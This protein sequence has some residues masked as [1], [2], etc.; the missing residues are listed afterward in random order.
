MSQAQAQS[1]SSPSPTDRHAIQEGFLSAANARLQDNVLVALYPAAVRLEGLL[2]GKGAPSN[3]PFVYVCEIASSVLSAPYLASL[4]ISAEDWRR[5]FRHLLDSNFAI[6]IRYIE[7]GK[8]DLQHTDVVV[9]TGSQARGIVVGMAKADK[10]IDHEARPF[11]K[12][13]ILGNVESASASVAKMEEEARGV[14]RRRADAEAAARESAQRAERERAAAELAARERAESAKRLQARIEAAETA[15]LAEM[16]EVGA[17]LYN[18]KGDFP[19]DA[20]RGRHL[21]EKA[22]DAGHVPAMLMLAGLAA[23]P[24]GF[25]EDNR[26]AFEWYEKASAT[27]SVEAKERLAELRKRVSG[28]D[29]R[30]LYEV[31]LPYAQWGGTGLLLLALMFGL[32]HWRQ[33]LFELVGAALGLAYKVD[34]ATSNPATADGLAGLVLAGA[35]GVLVLS[36]GG[37]WL[38]KSTSSVSTPLE[39]PSRNREFDISTCLHDCTETTSVCM[40]RLPRPTDAS[41]VIQRANGVEQ[42]RRYYDVCTASCGKIDECLRLRAAGA[43]DSYLKEKCR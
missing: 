10:L 16:F 27:G 6:P 25:S 8:C 36:Y 33:R 31:V 26:S 22:A 41:G 9:A 11:I 18:A 28:N 4:S 1:G 43:P 24:N 15:P 3:Q 37:S 39:Q 5:N 17:N 29:S 14:E 35:V 32:Y 23:Q 13:G 2:K 42:C 19:S 38:N 7:P 30:H 21:I 34:A 20:T 40:Q 12:F